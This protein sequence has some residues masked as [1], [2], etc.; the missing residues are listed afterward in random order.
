MADL[1]KKFKSLRTVFFQ[2][3]AKVKKSYGTG[4]A[5]SDIYKPKWCHFESLKFLKDN[6]NAEDTVSTIQSWASSESL[7]SAQSTS[8]QEMCTIDDDDTIHYTPGNNL[9]ESDIDDIIIDES[10]ALQCDQEM[11]PPSTSFSSRARPCESQPIEVPR[12][13]KKAV[14]S[15]DTIIAEAVNAL[16]AVQQIQNKEETECDAMGLMVTRSLEKMT[17][18]MRAQ[19][20]VEINSILLKYHPDNPN[21]TY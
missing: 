2:N 4:K 17:S 21:K 14:D 11:P 13:K 1:V 6:N 8:T 16:R 19:A 7:A 9:T 20:I 15:E 5:Q 3:D 18:W 12:K 10:A